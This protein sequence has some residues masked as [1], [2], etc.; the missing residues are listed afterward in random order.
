MAFSDKLKNLTKQAQE[1]VAEHKDKIHDAVDAVSV[2]A[3]EKTHGKYAAKITKFGQ[4]ASDAV[5]KLGGEAPADQA[6]A[7][8]PAAAP[9]ASAADAPATQAPAAGPSSADGPSF[10]DAPATEAPAVSP[11]S[12]APASAAPSGGPTFDE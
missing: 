1:A 2:A 3:N 11:H 5:E 12:A 9:T 7:G 4:K 6:A 8:D 10:A